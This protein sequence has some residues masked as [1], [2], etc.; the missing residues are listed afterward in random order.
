M[1]NSDFQILNSKKEKTYSGIKH[2]I[3]NIQSLAMLK[4]EKNYI[5]Y[6][7][8]N[9]VRQPY[10]FYTSFLI[11][12]IDDELNELKEAFKRGDIINMKEEC[13]DI[14]NIIDYLFEQLSQLKLYNNMELF[15]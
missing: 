4:M 13:A 2:R 1:G 11:K 9:Y 5:S 6:C 3:P 15:R 10:L 7:D 12:R 8:K 14:S